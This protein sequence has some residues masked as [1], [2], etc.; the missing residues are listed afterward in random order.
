[1]PHVELLGEEP[2]VG[3]D[4]DATGLD[5]GEEG[6]VAPVVVMAVAG[7]GKDVAREVGGPVGEAEAGVGRLAPVGDYAVDAVGEDEDDEV[8]EEGDE[9]DEAA[10]AIG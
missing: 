2:D 1:M 6:H 10:G 8:A 5:G 7:D 9:L 4:A 3:F